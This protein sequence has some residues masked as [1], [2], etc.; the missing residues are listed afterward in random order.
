MVHHSKIMAIMVQTPSSRES[1]IRPATPLCYSAS[2]R[3]F[4]SRAG[5]NPQRRM[6]RHHGN[7]SKITPIM[8]QTPSSRAAHIPSAI[9]R[10]IGHSRAG[11]NP[12][13]IM[14]RHHGN[15]SPI[16][17]QSPSSRAGQRILHSLRTSAIPRPIG[18]SRAGGNPQTKRDRHH[19]NHSKIMAITVQT[20]PSRAAHIP[21]ATQLCYSASHRSFPRRRE[22]TE[23]NG[24]ASRQSFPNHGDHGSITVQLGRGEHTSVAPRKGPRGK[25]HQINVQPP[26]TPHI[27][28]LLHLDLCNLVFRTRRHQPI[29]DH[30]IFLAATCRN[31]RYHFLK[32]S[33]IKVMHNSKP[34]NPTSQTETRHSFI[35]SRN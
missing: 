2:H 6:D 19:G 4:H 20:P 33:S 7:H 27:V 14:D 28:F 13:R 11:R 34:K 24:Q 18:H 25:L 12:Q 23:E 21:S 3:S 16:M 32:T 15:H 17:V 35:L 26:L 22:S 9:P 10:P 29:P 8:V 30:Q 1:H 31:C 5:G